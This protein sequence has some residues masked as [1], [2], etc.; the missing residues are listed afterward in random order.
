MNEEKKEDFKKLGTHIKKLRE[1][2]GLTLKELSERTGIRKEYL[3]K[4]EEG[5]AYGVL[6][7]KH[8][9]KIANALDISLCTMFKY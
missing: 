8:L 2:K 3:K 9:V 6:L 7:C 1:Q 5:T 4:I